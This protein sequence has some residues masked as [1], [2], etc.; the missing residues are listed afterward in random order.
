MNAPPDRADALLFDCLQLARTRRIGPVTY[1]RLMARFPSPRAAMDALPDM[2][3][4][5]GGRPFALAGAAAVEQEM[6]RVLALGARYIFLGDAE[7]PALLAQLPNAPVVLMVQGDA[8]LLA[9]QSIA[10][11]GARNAS[12]AA[13]RFARMMAG[14]LGEA[15][16]CVT[17]GLARGIDT[18]AH[19]GAMPH[20]TI[21][22]IASGLDVAFPPEN[23]ALQAQMGAQQALVTEYPP[24]TEPLARQFPHR[25]RIIAG[26]TLGTVVIE[27]A[28]RS[29]SLLTA[30]MAAE[31]GRDVMAVPGSPIDPRAQG[32]NGLIRDGATL[33]Q[34]VDD[35]I[36]AVSRMDGRMVRAPDV[37]PL[38]PSTSADFG[39][40]DVDNE[41]DRSLFDDL[42]NANDAAA[43]DRAP[44]DRAPDLAERQH[45]A[46][47]IGPTPVSVDEIVRQSGLNAATVQMAL[48]DMELAGRIEHHAGGKVALT[49]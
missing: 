27:A 3:R 22:V 47:L 41:H 35:V 21:G 31:A 6:A 14:G 30:R 24:G 7:Y 9:R 15:G 2:V 20:A 16:F 5:G 33:V 4:A 19:L 17:S 40:S 25:N 12:A 49:G 46:Q 37:R 18:A 43:V 23:R 29:G 34:T 28:P 8:A 38:F 10:I 36:E 11:V 1:R 44:A 48:L 13:C 45:L 39:G 32:C 42:A 26:A